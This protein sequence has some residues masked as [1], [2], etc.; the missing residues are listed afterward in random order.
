[1]WCSLV[2][3]F[4]TR[5]CPAVD[6][7]SH[8]NVSTHQGGILAS[9]VTLGD[10]GMCCQWWD[11]TVN[12]WSVFAHLHNKACFFRHAGIWS[13]V[14]F[15]QVANRGC[16]NSRIHVLFSASSNPFQSYTCTAAG[17]HALRDDPT[18][19]ELL[20][21]QS[22]KMPE[23]TSMSEWLHLTLLVSLSLS[24]SLWLRYSLC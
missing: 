24:P 5:I 17:Q 21:L 15:L 3:V 14:Q 10:D 13:V 18:C 8:E 16:Q 12:V 1:M 7:T 20:F 11:F 2:E 6:W 19:K 4:N 9:L 23:E 22:K